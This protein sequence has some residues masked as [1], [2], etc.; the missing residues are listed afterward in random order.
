M[1]KT[2]LLKPTSLSRIIS[3]A[4]SM[5]NPRNM[6]T[7]HNSSKGFLSVMLKIRKIIET[8]FPPI[9]PIKVCSISITLMIT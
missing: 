3:R 4:K 9:C 2:N 6:S 5:I 8:I 7:K 1:N